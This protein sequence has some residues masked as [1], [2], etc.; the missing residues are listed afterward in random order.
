MII[1]GTSLYFL[2]AFQCTAFESSV[3]FDRQGSLLYKMLVAL[4][5][6]KVSCIGI[7]NAVQN[8][9]TAFHFKTSLMCTFNA[10][11][12]QSGIGFIA[13]ALFGNF[14]YLT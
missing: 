14:A 6:N 2:K 13:G 4:C 3:R 9:Y 11:K 10:V 8:I 7:M 1:S 5:L 12:K